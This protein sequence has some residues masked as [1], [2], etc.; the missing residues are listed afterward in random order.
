MRSAETRGTGEDGPAQYSAGGGGEDGAAAATAGD[1]LGPA[2]TDICDWGVTVRR[3]HA[4]EGLLSSAL[5]RLCALRGEHEACAHAQVQGCAGGS[6]AAALGS[7][8]HLPALGQLG[9]ALRS[10]IEGSRSVT[11]HVP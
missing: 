11:S 2:E 1:Q 3:K 8:G 5:C 7:Q 9:Q 4:T 10:R 6:R